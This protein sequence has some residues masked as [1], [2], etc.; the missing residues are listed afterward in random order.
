MNARLRNRY[1]NAVEQERQARHSAE[2]AADDYENKLVQLITALVQS[3]PPLPID[4]RI[5]LTDLADELDDT[6]PY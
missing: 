2:I 3:N 4:L 6:I 5:W 1:I